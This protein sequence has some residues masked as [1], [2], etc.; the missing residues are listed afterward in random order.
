MVPRGPV[1]HHELQVTLTC[2][3]LCLS[4]SLDYNTYASITGWNGGQDQPCYACSPGLTSTSDGSTN[5]IPC[6]TAMSQGG[7]APF[8]APHVKSTSCRAE[9]VGSKMLGAMEKSAIE[10]S[11]IVDS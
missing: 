5:C 3:S 6:T 9:H 11:C 7:P 2:I 8:L 4:G 10:A 1:V